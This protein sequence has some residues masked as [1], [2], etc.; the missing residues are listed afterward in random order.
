MKIVKDIVKNYRGDIEVVSP[1]ND[2]STCIRIDIN[3]ASD[4]DLE[5]YE[6]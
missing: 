5:N 1:K 2:Y 4:K 6:V 3:K